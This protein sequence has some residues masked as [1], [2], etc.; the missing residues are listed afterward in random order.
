MLYTIAPI[1]MFKFSFSKV[2]IIMHNEA[3]LFSFLFPCR[4]QKASIKRFYPNCTDVWSNCICTSF[5]RFPE[6]LNWYPQPHAQY[7]S[8]H[9]GCP[10]I[11]SEIPSIPQESQP[12]KNG[13][14]NPSY[15]LDISKSGNRTT[16]IKKKK[17]LESKTGGFDHSDIHFHRPSRAIAIGALQCIGHTQSRLTILF[18]F[19]MLIALHLI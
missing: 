4:V 3:K 5:V 18:S 19:A 11:S 8:Q 10:T 1:S 15:L 16:I 12:G 7:C 6:S 9:D 2:Q 17:P 14:M 13:K